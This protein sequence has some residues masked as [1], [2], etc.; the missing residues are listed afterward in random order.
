MAL[1][2]EI[3]STFE[4]LFFEFKNLEILAFFVWPAKMGIGGGGESSWP[5]SAKLP[6][7]ILL[8]SPYIKQ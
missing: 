7:N 4:P 5:K 2:M 1:C 6:Q 8:T 3:L